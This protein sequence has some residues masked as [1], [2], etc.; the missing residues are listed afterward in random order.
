MVEGNEDNGNEVI[1][2]FGT[3]MLR[4]TARTIFNLSNQELELSF[5]TITSEE[6]GIDEVS[7]QPNYRLTLSLPD[8]SA[9]DDV[10]LKKLDTQAQ[11]IIISVRGQNWQAQG[12]EGEDDWAQYIYSAVKSELQKRG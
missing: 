1:H 6:D 3:H 7:G 9:V 12:Y 4:S 8:K 2:Y 11:Q 10:S 5:C